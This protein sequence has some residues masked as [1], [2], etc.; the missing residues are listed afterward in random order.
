MDASHFLKCAQSLQK[1]PLFHLSL[2]SR[3]LF[4]SNFLAWL[5]Q[6]YPRVLKP[7]FGPRFDGAQP[8]ADGVGREERDLDLVV[9]LRLPTGGCGTLVIENKIKAVVDIHQLERYDL[10]IAAKCANEEI[11]GKYV[12]S[13]VDI[14][15]CAP[16][17]DVI[18]YDCIAA[19]IR[20]EAEHMSTDDQVMWAVREHGRIA[21]GLYCICSPQTFRRLRVLAS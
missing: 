5:I 4:H 19:A 18:T 20:S 8:L 12:L 7:I 6:Q 10:V 15:T 14:A 17:W 2:S 1:N 11:L 3:E 21:T 16:G 13:L 9:R